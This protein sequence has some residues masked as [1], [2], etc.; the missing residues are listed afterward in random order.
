MPSLKTNRFL[1]LSRSFLFVM[2][3]SV[4]I[5]PAASAQSSIEPDI[6]SKDTPKSP[7]DFDL[8]NGATFNLVVTNYGFSVAGQYRRV[9]SRNSELVFEG[10]IGTLRD[11]REQA[12]F[13]FGQQIIPNKFQRV[14]NFPVMAGFRHRML[15]RYIDDNFRLYI[16]G[17]AGPSF[18]FAYPY[19]ED[20]PAPDGQPAQVQLPNSRINDVFQ[21]WGDG[22]WK[23]GYVSKTALAV[24]FGSRFNTLTSLE[25]GLMT[26]Y[27][28]DGIQIMEPNSLILGDD[29]RP[30]D[31]ARGDG[32]DA[33]DWFFTPTITLSFGGMW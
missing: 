25:F 6:R 21:G 7:R 32:F 11:P 28:P 22:N 29:G 14:F 31:V 13:F 16:S 10:G 5:M 12:F 19:F 27:F 8:A 26:H 30:V 33:R 9:V 23:I 1:M 2:L 15:S 18:A 20:V 4:L 17:M 24:D 3:A